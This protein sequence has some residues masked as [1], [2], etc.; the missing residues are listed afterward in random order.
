MAEDLVLKAD[1]PGIEPDE[2][3]VKVEDGVLTVTAHHEE[4]QEEKGEGF[5]RRE[6]S[7]S[8]FTRRLPVPEGFEASDVE[9]KVSDGVVEVKIPAG[10]P[11]AGS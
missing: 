6:E 11:E 1:V 3:E 9:T 7:Y 2:V 5:V 4:K 10:R 8:S